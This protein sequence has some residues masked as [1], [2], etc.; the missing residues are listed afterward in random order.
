[1]INFIIV[2]I[3]LKFFSRIPIFLEE[4]SSLN[5]AINTSIQFRII[6]LTNVWK[7]TSNGLTD[8]KKLIIALQFVSQWFFC[9]IMHRETN[10][11]K[12]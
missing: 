5:A 2:T 3:E 4:N 7:E 8:L 1:M 10:I 11:W 12:K 6:N 9:T